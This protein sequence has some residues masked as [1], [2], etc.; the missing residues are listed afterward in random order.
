[1]LPL[2]DE[3]V[4]PTGQVAV[5]VP[6]Q[7][8]LEA[9]RGLGPGD[10]CVVWLAYRLERR[11][12][13]Q[14]EAFGGEADAWVDLGVDSEPDRVLSYYHLDGLGSVRVVTDATGQVA[15]ACDTDVVVGRHEFLPFGEEWDGPSPPAERR[16]F[17]GQ[18][19]DVETGLDYFGARH[20]QALWGRFTTIDP[21]YTW[22][23]NLVDPQRW[24]RYSYVRNNPL[25]YVDPDGR[26]PLLPAMAIGAI[27]GAVQNL[28]FNAAINWYLDRPVFEHWHRRALRAQR[29][30]EL[31]ALSDDEALAAAEMLLTVAAEVGLP[32]VHRTSSGLVQQQALF[33][34]KTRS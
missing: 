34:R 26:M 12:N 18:E 25:R 30:R 4:S 21:V 3:V 20:Y 9:C 31:A 22:Q 11:E 13:D 17:T 24:N 29:A 32:P 27:V 2:P 6:L 5:T 28:A 33:H 23:E 14:W 16:L 19:R 1:V 7:V 8:P 10:P 15:R